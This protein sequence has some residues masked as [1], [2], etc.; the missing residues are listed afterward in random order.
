MVKSSIPK[1]N[2]SKVN[3]QNRLKLESEK[4]ARMKLAEEKHKKRLK[5]ESQRK[6]KRLKEETERKARR[7]REESEK[8]ARMKLAEEKHKKRLKEESQRKA[9]RL[10]EETERKA[11]RA[12]EESAK[13]ARMLKVEKDRKIR[14]QQEAKAKQE[15]QKQLRMLKQERE[16][17]KRKFL[18]ERKIRQ[19]KV[20]R[21]RMIKRKKLE[22]EKLARRRKRESE[23]RERDKRKAEEKRVKDERRAAVL[24]AR[25]EARRKKEL[26]KV[27]T[28]EE[29]LEER[30]STH[31]IEGF[32]LEQVDMEL[33]TNHICDVVMDY[34]AEGILQKELWD[35]LKLDDK[36][37]ARLAL[38]LERMG[39]IA[40]KKIL[41]D[42]RW[43]YRLILKK[44]PVSTMS[45]LNAPCLTCE[46]EQKCTSDGDISPKTCQLLEDW[47]FITKKRMKPHEA[48]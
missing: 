39:L 13:K 19:A 41:V 3:Q 27:K 5:E 48:A 9:K 31:E 28:L 32:Q 1:K 29:E 44:T 22:S 38:K 18:Q 24:A 10:K 2:S 30:L 37:G 7:A 21:E 40:R 26:L 15:K 8:R 47:V 12:R 25:D 23:K 14:K 17:A 16:K 20:E 45:L 33:L 34:D 6:A 43:T 36:D 4:R 35:M 46:V 11:R 42:G